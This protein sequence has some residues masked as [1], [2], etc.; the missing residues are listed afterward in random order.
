MMRQKQ[1]EV[2]SVLI[3]VVLL[4]KMAHNESELKIIEEAIHVRL[5]KL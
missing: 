2:N 5:G 3:V 4:F 1:V